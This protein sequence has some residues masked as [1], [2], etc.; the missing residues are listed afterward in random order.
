MFNSRKTNDVMIN[1]ST[2][3]AIALLTMSFTSALANENTLPD[4]AVCQICQAG[5][6]AVADTTEHGGQIYYFCSVTCKEEF[7]RDP[8]AYIAPPPEWAAQIPS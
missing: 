8:H 1:R 4:S 2:W 6:E 3:I 7:L 5:Q